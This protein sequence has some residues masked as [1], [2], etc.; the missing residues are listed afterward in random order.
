VAYQNLLNV[1]TKP[2]TDQF[3]DLNTSEFTTPVLDAVV[4]ELSDDDLVKHSK[5]LTEKLEHL[6]KEREQ[7]QKEKEKDK[8]QMQR[9]MSLNKHSDEPD[10]DDENDDG[11]GPA[12]LCHDGFDRCG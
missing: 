12:C 8:E 4:T 6:K 10:E 5:V 7:R 1:S 2:V 3:D 9:Q 11:C